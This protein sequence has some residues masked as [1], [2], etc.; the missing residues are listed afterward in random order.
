MCFILLVYVYRLT[1]FRADVGAGKCLCTLAEIKIVL[2][3]TSVV[4]FTKK[5][6]FHSLDIAIGR[7]CFS[8]EWF[9]INC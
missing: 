2:I 9:H 6:A 3:A 5:V 4:D 8:V 7:L 1:C